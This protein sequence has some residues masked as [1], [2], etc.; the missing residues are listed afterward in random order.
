MYH[1]KNKRYP[2]L[3]HEPHDCAWHE[4]TFWP[5]EGLGEGE[6][7]Q[8]VIEGQEIVIGFEADHAR[9][10]M[11]CRAFSLRGTLIFLPIEP[12]VHE[13]NSRG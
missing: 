13:V 4:Q 5:C 9:S 11:L 1:R 12:V 2:T 8:P 3:S 7:I 6:D 10:R